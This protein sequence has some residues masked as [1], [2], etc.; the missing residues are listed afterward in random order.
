[1]TGLDT[2]VLLRI[3]V[4]DD[5]DQMARARDLVDR[6]Y[7]DG[8]RCYVND[9]VLCELVWVLGS[10]YRFDR[11]EI[12]EALERLLD[13]PHF[14]VGDD[15]RVQSAIATYRAGR[16]DFADIM[17][18]AVNRDAGCERTVTFDRKAARLDLFETL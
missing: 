3:I 8:S 18:G 4:R 16:A 1:M 5:A 17:I 11:H 9:I 7:R 15:A 14:R 12:A 6:V 2:N 10:V 13:T